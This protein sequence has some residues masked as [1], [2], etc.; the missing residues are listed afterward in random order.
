MFSDNLNCCTR[1][2]FVVVL[3]LLSLRS[4]AANAPEGAALGKTRLFGLNGWCR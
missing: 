1:V 3:L 4:N 2:Q